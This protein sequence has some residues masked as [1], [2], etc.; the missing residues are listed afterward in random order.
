MRASGLPTSFIIL[1]SVLLGVASNP[2]NYIALSGGAPADPRH[3]HEVGGWYYYGPK[4]AH[5]V[6]VPAIYLTGYELCSESD[7]HRTMRKEVRP[8]GGASASKTA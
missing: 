4:Y 3:R 7:A 1:T 2:N 5:L 8:I 6:D